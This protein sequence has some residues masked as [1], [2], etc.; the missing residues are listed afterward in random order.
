MSG[1]AGQTTGGDPIV[2]TAARIIIFD[3]HDRV[4]LLSARDPADGKVVWFVPGGG[5]EPGESLE[6]AAAR[7]LAEEVPLAGVL[8]LRGPVWTRHHDFTWNGKRID[9]TEW[10]FVGR[11]GH[12]LDAAE[13]Q[14]DGPEEQFFEGARWVSVA[15]LAAWTGNA[16]MAP[17][18]LAEL[19]ADLLA[20]RWPSEP[21]D[22]GI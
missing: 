11:L 3:A 5:V 14:L 9:Q 6:Q 19:L 20:G 16:I 12:A 2:R 21:I 10:F 1:Q 17:G 18:R 22:T 4:L 13:I 7:E 15:E 8:T